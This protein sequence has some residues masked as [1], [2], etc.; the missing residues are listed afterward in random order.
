MFYN[1]QRLHQSLD[2]CTPNEVER[3]WTLT[4]QWDKMTMSDEAEAGT[5]GEQPAE[6]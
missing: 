6:E 3:E 1:S 2:Y 4:S 5:A